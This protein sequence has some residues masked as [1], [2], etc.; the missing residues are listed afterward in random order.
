MLD[1]LQQIVGLES[2]RTGA[3]AAPWKVNGVTV[4]VVLPRSAEQ[5]AAVLALASEAGWRV[6]P[7]GAGSWL[8]AGPAAPP[9]DLILATTRLAGVAEY[10]PAD[11]TVGVEAGMPL[12]GLQRLLAD[13]RQWLA[14]DPPGDPAGTVGATVATASAG[15]LRL[16]YGTPRDLVLGVQLATGDGRLL[17]LGG[18][19][20]KNAAGFDLTRLVV[21][22]RGTL[23]VITRLNLRLRALPATD[24]TVVLHVDGPAAA[25]ERVAA[26][27][28]SG[29]E[30]VALEI[31]SPALGRLFPGDG[32]TIAARLH[33][34]AEV[35]ADGLRRL[36]A[37]AGPGARTL[38]PAEAWP[39]WAALQSGEGAAALSI[40]LADL[41]SRL[42]R[43][44]QLAMDGIA[45]AGSTT[46]EGPWGIAVHAGDGIVRVLAPAGTPPLPES[47]AARFVAAM[48]AARAELAQRRATL[49]VARG[50]EILGGRLDAYGDVGPTLRIMRSVKQEFDP[51]GILSPGRFVVQGCSE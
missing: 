16:G 49:I 40:R 32:W 47:A 13:E 42:E 28:A 43:T 3:A 29:A 12:G 30:P 19:V 26:M 51:A 31:L 21:G 27:R 22:S 9:P 34:D 33:G 38:S 7:A 1:R 4:P 45:A 11:L 50:V 41:P 36:L 35:V 6:L 37:A 14:L 5:V 48:E 46:L 10:E 24:R 8:D 18:R 17:E 44:L 39:A 2:L 23:G 20:V 25:L 15:P